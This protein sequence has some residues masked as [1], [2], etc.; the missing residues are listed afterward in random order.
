MHLVG[1]LATKNILII[2]NASFIRK[3]QSHIYSSHA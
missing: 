2:F 1:K 3:D